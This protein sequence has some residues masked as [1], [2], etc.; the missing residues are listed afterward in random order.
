MRGIQNII[1]VWNPRENTIRFPHLAIYLISFLVRGQTWKTLF[2]MFTNMCAPWTVFFKNNNF[3]A[4]WAQK[5][6]DGPQLNSQPWWGGGGGVQMYTNLAVWLLQTARCTF[7]DSQSTTA[8]NIN[9]LYILIIRMMLC[10]NVINWH[11]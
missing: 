7:T 2:C 8:I 10:C 5:K 9:I 1:N 6:T 3:C 4:L 11:L